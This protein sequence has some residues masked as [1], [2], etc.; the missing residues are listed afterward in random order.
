MDQ[1]AERREFLTSR[2]ANLTPD[3]AGIVSYGGVRRVPGLRREEVAQLAGVSVD[4]YTRFETGKI[5]GVSDTV[6]ESIAR[7]L[8]LDDAERAHLR[9]LVAT[10]ST[11]GRRALRAPAHQQVRPGVRLLLDSMGDVPAMIQNGRMDILASNALGDALYLGFGATPERPANFA[12]F[13]FLDPRAPEFYVDWA[14]AAADSVAMLHLHAGRHPEDKALADLIGD[15]SVHSQPFRQWWAQHDVR[16]HSAG[17]K[18]FH[19]PIA[20]DLT[21]A[22][23]SFDVAADDGQILVT[24]TAEP[25]SP[26]AGALGL[27]ASWIATEQ[28]AR[29]TEPATDSSRMSGTA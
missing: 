28:P 18:S 22:F 24:Y 6:L 27:L 17:S 16:I 1:K 21:V 20:G 5:A 14:R 4:Y 12:R 11:R 8:R 23:E 7:A 26:S 19:H 3:E 10:P 13:V 9:D 25:G 2:R 15:L 29:P